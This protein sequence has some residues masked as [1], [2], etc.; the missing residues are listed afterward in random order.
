MISNVSE[1]QRRLGHCSR[2]KITHAHSAHFS[3]DKDIEN[4]PDCKSKS[5]NKVIEEMNAKIDA[6]TRVVEALTANKTK[7]PTCQ[8]IP[9]Q[10]KPKL[11]P[12]MYDCPKCIERG[13]R[14]CSHCFVCGEGG[15]RAA[16]CFKERQAQ[17]SS[18]SF[19][20]ANAIN[21]NGQQ[22][23][24]KPANVKSNSHV[25]STQTTEETV[26]QLVGSK[27]R[28]KCYL[29]SYAVDCLLDTGAQVSLLDRHFVKTYLPDHKV[30][31]LAELIGRKDLSV[32]AINGKP[33]SYDGCVGVMVSLPDNS[34]PNLAVQVP[35]L[36]SSLPLDC[37]L[38][39]FNVIEQ[40]MPNENAELIPA[41][42]K[43]LVVQ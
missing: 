36:V 24:G 25:P 34:D 10:I 26:A 28:I 43:L 4:P 15:H 1:R 7:E 3:P 40:L 16:Q 12:R 35:F 27:C 21:I 22:N 41:L 42:V 33:L 13:T 5:K 2:Q 20:D 8:C 14:S 18:R 37:P 11:T 38:I 19:T 9:K 6:L 29:H 17:G 31:P 39:G 23:A 30:R 32:L